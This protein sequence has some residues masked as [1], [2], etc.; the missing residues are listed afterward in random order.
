MTGRAPGF[1]EKYFEQGMQRPR[2]RDPF[3]LK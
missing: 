3:E 2:E 1:R